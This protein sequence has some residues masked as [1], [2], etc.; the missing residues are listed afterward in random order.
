MVGPALDTLGSMPDDPDALAKW[1]KGL[2]LSGVLLD[3]VVLYGF[4]FRVLGG[5]LQQSL[6]F[7]AAGIGLMIVWWPKRP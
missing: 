1:R 4:A 7:Y 3:A 5:T 6:P 2:V